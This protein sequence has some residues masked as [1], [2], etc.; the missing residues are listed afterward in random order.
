MW[1]YDEEIKEN[2]LK[3]D[4]IL[5]SSHKCEDC[6]KVKLSPKMEK[7][8]EDWFKDFWKYNRRM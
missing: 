6:I 3:N 7:W 2:D 1:K 8:F 4:W 5:D